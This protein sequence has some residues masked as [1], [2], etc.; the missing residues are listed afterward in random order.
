MDCGGSISR[1]GIRE[2]IL[3]TDKNNLKIFKYNSKIFYYKIFTFSNLSKK[4]STLYIKMKLEENMNL[5]EKFL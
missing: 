1:V 5:F 4:I 2:I 3:E